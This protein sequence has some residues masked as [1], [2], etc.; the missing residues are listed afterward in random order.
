[1][2]GPAYIIDCQQILSEKC[3]Y[4]APGVVLLFSNRQVGNVYLV[5]M[6]TQK[7][8]LFCKATGIVL[9]LFIAVYS[10]PFL[11]VSLLH[12]HGKV[13]VP[14]IIVSSLM[15][16]MIYILTITRRFGLAFFDFGFNRT[17]LKFLLPALAISLPVAIAITLALQYV[18]EKNPFGGV[19]FAIWELFLYFGIGASIQEEIIFRGLLQTVIIKR[20]GDHSMN[21][22]AIIVAVLFAIVHLEVGIFTALGALA[23]GLMAG[24]LRN[25]S[26]SI[27]PS[28]IA[29]AIFNICSII[30]VIKPLS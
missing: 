30:W 23:L 18:H 14:F 12:L 25:K 7:L 13:I 24:I 9:I 16:A 8:L 1:M 2:P 11:L 20:L 27:W 6:N 22:A 26:G 29:H 28:I 3:W 21:F 15:L 4:N 5:S 10:P 19:S 17:N